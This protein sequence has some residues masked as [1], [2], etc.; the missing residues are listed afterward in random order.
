VTPLH[1]EA[2]IDHLVAAVTAI[3]PEL[4]PRRAL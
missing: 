1:R 2:E 4:N 3:W